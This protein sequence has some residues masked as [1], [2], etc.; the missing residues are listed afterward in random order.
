[1]MRVSKNQMN[2]QYIMVFVFIAM[3]ASFSFSQVYGQDW[4]GGAE[5]LGITVYDD[6]YTVEKFATGVVYPTNMTFVGE[7]ILVLEKNT[8]KVFRIQD[9]GIMYNEPVLDVPVIFQESAGLLGIA[10]TSDHVY[11]YFTESLSGVDEYNDF[12]NSRDAVYQYD[13]NGK[14]LIN[15]ILIKELPSVNYHHHGGVITTGQNNEVYFVIGSQRVHTAFQNVPGDRSLETSSIF[16][17]DTQNNNNIE[18]FAMGIRNSFGLDIDPVTGYLWD[19][20]NGPDKF[21]EI[22][23]VKPRFNSGWEHAMGPAIISVGL[24]GKI[25]YDRFLI[26]LHLQPFENFE[27]SDPEFSW[28]GTVAPTAISFPDKD[29]FT[30]YSDWLF[31]GGFQTG[32]V[33]N[34]QLNSDRTG[35]VFSTP[36]LSDLVLDDNDETDEII[37][38]DGFQGVVDIK[39]HDG[40]MYVLSFGDGSIYK[41]YSKERA[42]EKKTWSAETLKLLKTRT[43]YEYVNL[44]NTDFRGMSLDNANISNVN[45]TNVNLSHSD[46]SYKDLT[47]TILR[48]ADL[49]N[50][51]LTGVDLSGRDLTGTILKGLDLSDKDLTGTILKE[52]DLSSMDLTGVDLSHKDLTGTILKGLDLSDKDL[53]GTILYRATLTDTILP[54]DYLSGKNFESVIFDGVDLSGKDLSYSDFTYASFIDTNLENANLSQAIFVSTDLTKIKNKSLAGADLTGTSFGHSDLSHVDLSDVTLGAT[55]FWNTDLSG[56]G[57]T[58]IYDANTLHYHLNNLVQKLFN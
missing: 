7:D 51:N 56:H 54:N 17:I 11:L 35:F 47:G 49:T 15:P 43:D 29:G 27:Y 13:W 30:K 36:G 1:M 44:S 8:G 37:F 39:F 14:N 55:N 25:N 31:A 10:S 9:N 23:L 48:G 26:Q 16:K 33:Y 42:E 2:I 38:A 57:S 4:E 28:Y 19:T 58:I 18:L 32:T 12:K 3:L 5:E 52:V 6:D 41:I 24:N 40:V 21:D 53:T 45:L 22:N 34:F 50:A 46:L 20:E